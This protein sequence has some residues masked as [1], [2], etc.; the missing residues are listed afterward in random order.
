MTAQ[1]VGYGASAISLFSIVSCL[2]YVPYLISKV[3]DIRS[4][5]DLKMDEFEVR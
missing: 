5:L 4:S 3:G 1:I 2:I